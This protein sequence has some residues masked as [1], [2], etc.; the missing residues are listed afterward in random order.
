MVE[1]TCLENKRLFTG[2]VSS[3]LTA[4]AKYFMKT[5][6][7]RSTEYEISD[8]FLKR[9]SARAMSGEKI[10]KEEI[11]T[12]CE[13]ARWAPSS[14]NEQP[15][16]FMYAMRDTEDFNLFLS[17]TN[18]G[19]Q[20]WCKNAGALIIELSKKNFSNEK[21]NFAHSFDAG[22]AWEN[23]ALQG[24]NMNLVIHPIGGYN[25]EA[26][27]REL[28]IPKE[29][30]VEIMISVGRPGKIEDLPEKFQER[31]KPSQRKNLE[32]I[33]FEEKKF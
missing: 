25:K 4:S 19:N 27:I 13:A 16:R 5:T 8:I 3:N 30:E 11:M 22:A 21:E 29:Y 23:L 26:L 31:E 6:N 20:S 15:W 14:M 9:Y 7:N 1:G 24:V 33:V 2:S 18:E 10:S 17:F 12:L 32:E 28:N